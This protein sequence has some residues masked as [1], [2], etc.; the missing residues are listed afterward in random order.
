MVEMASARMARRGPVVPRFDGSESADGTAI[1][2]AIEES[3]LG[4]VPGGPT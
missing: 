1:R 4:G 3:A 2:Q